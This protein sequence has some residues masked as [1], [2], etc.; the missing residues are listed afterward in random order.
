MPVCAIVAAPL[1]ASSRFLGLTPDRTAARPSQLTQVAGAP[2]LLADQPAQDEGRPVDL[3]PVAGE[4]EHHGD[5]RDR[6]ERDPD[7]QRQ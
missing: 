5:D 7:R 3:G 6:A 2:D 4:H 1:T